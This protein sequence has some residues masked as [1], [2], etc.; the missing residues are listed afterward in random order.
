MRIAEANNYFSLL[1][2]SLFDEEIIMSFSPLNKKE[3]DHLV[4]KKWRK[5]EEIMIDDD[6]LC[7]D[8]VR[9]GL[10]FIFLRKKMENM[11]IFTR[12]LTIINSS[13]SFFSI[14]KSHAFYLF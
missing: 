14:Q 13:N 1:S 5:D 11:D 2:Y 6:H 7:G 10:K 12:K 3:I 4:K 8:I 9:L